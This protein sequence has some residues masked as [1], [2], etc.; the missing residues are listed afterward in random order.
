MVIALLAYLFLTGY[1]DRAPF[2]KPRERKWVL[3]RLREE[4]GGKTEHLPLAAFE[5]NC[6]DWR[7]WNISLL[8]LTVTVP[9]Y[10]LAFFIPT[11]LTVS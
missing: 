5:E 4:R 9:T 2:L 3:D 1:P 11:I 7:I 6:S 10:G 8:Y